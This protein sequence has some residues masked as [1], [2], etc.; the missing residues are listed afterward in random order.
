MEDE[1]SIFI[2]IASYR[3]PELLPTIEDCLNNAAHPERL[4]FC[5]AWQHHPDDEWDRLDKYKDDKRFI[6]LDVDSKESRGVCWARNLTQQHYK[7]QG[8]TLQIDSHMRFV[9]N[10]DA[11]CIA[12]IK[13]LRGLG[14]PKPV[15]TAYVP[16]YQPKNDPDGR[17]Q[18][19]Y[20]INFDRFNPDGSILTRPG[21]VANWQKL[22]EPLL[23]RFY[24]AHF[25]FAPGGF[26]KH[27]PELYF[28]GEEITVY[29]RA[30]T[31]GYDFFHPH[32]IVAWHE[33]TREGRQKHWDDVSL[34]SELDGKSKKKVRQL[35][36]MESMD[37]GVTSFGEFD[38]GTERSLEDYE[39]FVGIYF[40]D[41][42]VS[43]HTLKF[44]PPPDPPG[45]LE[46]VNNYM[47]KYVL[48]FPEDFKKEDDADFIAVIVEDM[49]GKSLYR[50]DLS[51]EDL[52]ISLRKGYTI[53]EYEGPDKPHV[54]ILWKHLKTGDWGS[55][56]LANCYLKGQ[57]DFQEHP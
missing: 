33:Y 53:F 50:K 39:R 38:L 34:W 29:A 20:Q 2:Q 41:R 3:D 11:L 18:T 23:A 5:I 21:F 25:T 15:L 55:Q 13:Q 40:K 4:T 42:K 16:P 44:N 1:N 48:E 26:I 28:T 9:K 12:M 57:F 56:A 14:Y 47:L 6:I 7:G 35:L 36:K 17:T 32:K 52:A 37:E 8:Y 45:G 46:E 30:F 51:K 54:W 49:H 19:I 27:D 43:K 24:S 22:K 31:H 10:W